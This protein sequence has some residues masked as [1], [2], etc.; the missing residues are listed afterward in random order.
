MCSCLLSWPN[1]KTAA[2]TTKNLYRAWPILAR[3]G[4][5]RNCLIYKAQGKKLVLV[6]ING[7]SSEQNK[8]NI[9][10]KQNINPS[11]LKQKYFSG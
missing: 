7:T 9:V 5:Y 3:P 4:N 11:N 10:L 1:S 8:V 6:T 2:A